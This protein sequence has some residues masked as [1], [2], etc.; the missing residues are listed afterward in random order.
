[1]LDITC[2]SAEDRLGMDFAQAYKDSTLYKWVFM[3]QSS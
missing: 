1:M 3:Q 2:K